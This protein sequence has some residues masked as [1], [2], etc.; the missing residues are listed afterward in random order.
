MD[1]IGLLPHKIK[2][3]I[4]LIEYKTP[5]CLI[6]PVLILNICVVTFLFRLNGRGKNE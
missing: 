6:Y 2:Y 4:L 1:S 3:R 5:D